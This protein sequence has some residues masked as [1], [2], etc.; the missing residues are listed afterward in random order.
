MNKSYTEKGVLF[1]VDNG[2]IA[3]KLPSQAKR[4]QK[5]ELH[6]QYRRAVTSIQAELG[7]YRQ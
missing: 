1:W 7:Y 6:Y 3:T 2:R 5:H 4:Y